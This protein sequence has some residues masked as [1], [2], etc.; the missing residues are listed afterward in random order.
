[1][2]SHPNAHLTQKGRLWLINKHLLYH[3]HLAELAT[4]PGISL[5]FAYKLLARYRLGGT[6]QKVSKRS[7]DLC[8]ACAVSP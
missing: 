2:H 1:M 6:A 3:R 8:S 4:E 5:N 7:N